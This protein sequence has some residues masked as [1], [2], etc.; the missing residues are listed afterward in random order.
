[1]VV[2]TTTNGTQALARARQATRV[3]TG[4]FANLN[5]VIEWLAQQSGPVHLVCAGTEGR[6]A[7]EDVLC[8]GAIASGLSRSRAGFDLSDDGVVL[9]LDL[10]EKRFSPYDRFLDALRTSLGG[11]NLMTL[12]LEPDIVTAARIDATDIVPELSREPW[13]IT[14][15]ADA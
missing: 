1:T 7:L 14:A 5:A 12:G 10:L 4:A 6:V 13:Q 15:A 9:A 8:A 3:V 2:F 11:R